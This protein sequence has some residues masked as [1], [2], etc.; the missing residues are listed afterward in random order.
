M[1]SD[2][3]TAA[4][5]AVEQRHYIYFERPRCPECGSIRLRAYRSTKNGDRSVTRNSRCLDCG[6]KLIVV[7]E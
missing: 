1:H 7:A 4:A 3:P 2:D 5:A 6:A